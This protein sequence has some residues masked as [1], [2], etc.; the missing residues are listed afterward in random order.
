MKKL[1]LILV[2]VFFICG[3]GEL[4]ETPK[5]INIDSTSVQEIIANN[6][7]VIIDVREESEYNTEHVKGSINIPVGSI[8]DIEDRVAKSVEVIVYCKS[9]NRSKT[10]ASRIVELG[11]EKV[12][13]LG[14]ITSITLEK[15]S[16]DEENEVS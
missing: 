3:C 12:Y 10:A 7:Y 11:Y 1:L 9:G 14:G 2:S 16:G 5:V 13:D 15:V 4:E 6:N 8:E